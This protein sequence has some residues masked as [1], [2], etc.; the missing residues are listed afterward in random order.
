MQQMQQAS[1]P[2][3]LG[4]NPAYLAPQPITLVF[5]EGI[6]LS[7]EKEGIEEPRIIKSVHGTEY[8]HCK[9]SVSGLKGRK[10]ESSPARDWAPCGSFPG[11]ANC[12]M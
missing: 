11:I 3:P 5:H 6:S 1:I 4:V 9:G 7:K 8:L 10:C 12:S 2:H